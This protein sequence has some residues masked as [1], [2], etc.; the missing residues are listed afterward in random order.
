VAGRPKLSYFRQDKGIDREKIHFYLDRRLVEA[1][2]SICARA[3]KATR[4]RKPS[5]SEP[6]EGLVWWGIYCATNHR[7]EGEQLWSYEEADQAGLVPVIKNAK[8]GTI[9]EGRFLEDDYSDYPPPTPTPP[10]RRIK[11]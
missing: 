9:K 3:G 1:V 2:R 8:L 5:L 7:D 11:P 4:R 10:A 6:V